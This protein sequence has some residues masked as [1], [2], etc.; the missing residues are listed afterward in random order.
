MANI[1][2][3]IV[4]TIDIMLNYKKGWLTLDQAIEKM[5]RATG[6]NESVAKTFIMGMSRDNVISLQAKRDVLNKQKE[7]ADDS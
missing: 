1:K 2:P 4:D 5:R 6:L 7:S 3:E